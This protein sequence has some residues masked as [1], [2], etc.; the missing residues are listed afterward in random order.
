MDS[1]SATTGKSEDL[2]K[3]HDPD[4]LLQILEELWIEGNVE[5]QTFRPYLDP[6]IVHTNFRPQSVFNP[7]QSKGPY[8]ETFYQ[9]VYK[10]FSKL[11]DNPSK[12]GTPNLSHDE[13]QALKN[14][15]AT[16]IL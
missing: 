4:G 12:S 1:D 9:A 10:D 16:K 14:L 6:D 13:R 5:S 15:K 11:C 7:T 3:E 8:I 2:V